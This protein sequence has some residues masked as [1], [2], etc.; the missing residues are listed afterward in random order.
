MNVLQSISFVVREKP[1]LH[2]YPLRPQQQLLARV[3]LPLISRLTSSGGN[4]G[5]KINKFLVC[6]KSIVIGRNLRI[7]APLGSTRRQLILCLASFTA[8]RILVDSRSIALRRAV[9]SRLVCPM[10]SMS[11]AY[12]GNGRAFFEKQLFN[13]TKE[14]SYISLGTPYE[15]NVV[16]VRKQRKSFF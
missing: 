14:S 9:T 11:S 15:V 5:A 3:M 13:S 1:I 4:H 10:K 8:R 6:I 2:N 7:N 12:A 16:S